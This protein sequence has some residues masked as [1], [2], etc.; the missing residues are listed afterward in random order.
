M[1]KNIITFCVL[2]LS[3]TTYAANWSQTN[4]Q[5]LHGASYKKPGDISYS[6]TVVTFEHL[7]QWDYGTNFFFFDITS[8]DT[9]SSTS[10]YGEFSPAFSFGKMGVFTPPESFLKDVLLQLNFEIPQGP[11][12]RVNLAGVTFE[13]KDIGFDYLATQFLYRDAMGIDGHTGQFTVVWLKRFGGDSV[14]FEFSGFLDWA[15]AEDTLKDNVHIQANVLYDLSRKTAQKVPLKIGLEYK[16]WS[17]KYGIDGL[18][19][20]VPQAKLLWNF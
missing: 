5:F 6:A 20:N 9:E 17:N 18:N 8:P 19:E 4:M 10:Y 3:S 15:G 16:Y 11:S 14:P 2:I 13:W 1:L 12:R 7:S